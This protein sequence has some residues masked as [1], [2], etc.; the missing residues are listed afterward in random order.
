MQNKS[1]SS[2][3]GK[4]IFKSFGTP[5]IEKSGF[6]GGKSNKYDWNY[7]YGHRWAVLKYFVLKYST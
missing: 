6:P 7:G 5:D 1:F 4:R 3:G 2:I